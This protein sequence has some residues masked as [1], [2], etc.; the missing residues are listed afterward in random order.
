MDF[1]KMKL[2]LKDISE[3]VGQS[4]NGEVFFQAGMPDKM[5]HELTVQGYNAAPAVVGFSLSALTL[6][7]WVAIVTIGYILMQAAYL[8]WK[9]RREAEKKNETK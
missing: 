1:T 2:I 3:K 6:N 9:W 8:A 4:Q 7:E 5:K